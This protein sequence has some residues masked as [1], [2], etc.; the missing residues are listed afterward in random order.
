MTGK[1]VRWENDGQWFTALVHGK[2][3]MRGS[4]RGEVLDPGNF[5]GM[6]GVHPYFVEEPLKLGQLL[7]NL[8]D[9]LITEVPALGIQEG[10]QQ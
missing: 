10:G 4:W 2:G 5:T 7:P 8:L 3:A 1:I 9:E 6:G